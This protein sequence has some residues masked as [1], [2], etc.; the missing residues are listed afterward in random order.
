MRSTRRQPLGSLDISNDFFDEFEKDRPATTVAS[1]K[2]KSRLI[3]VKHLD[4]SSSQKEKDEK[5]RKARQTVTGSSD[6]YKNFVDLTHVS[7]F[8]LIK[9]ITGCA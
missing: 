6:T 1:E 2:D 5:K 7:N 4:L 3:E 8:L 9:T